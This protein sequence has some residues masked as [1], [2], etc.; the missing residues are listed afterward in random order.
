MYEDM[1]IGNVDTKPSVTSDLDDL[2]NNLTSDIQNFNKYIS[3]VNK[4]KQENSIEEKEILE[5]KQRIDKA[6]LDFENYVKTKNEE[7]IKKEKEID[8]YLNLQ[9]QNLLK[10]EEDFKINMD[11]SINELEIVK[12]EVELQKNRLEEEK[13]QF[14]TF[15]NLEINRIKHAKEMLDSEKT[16]FEKYKEVTIRKID[17]EN[18]NI[19]QKCDRFKEL[20]NQF[21]SNFKPMIKEEE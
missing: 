1:L 17:L 12:K 11:N 9:K 13:S 10:A 20:I 19:E 2:F 5:E 4:Q 16:Q 21:N 8:E 15:K 7:Y 6:K 14:E 18:K 3:D